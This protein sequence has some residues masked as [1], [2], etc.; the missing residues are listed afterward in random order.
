MKTTMLKKEEA[1]HDWF[2]VDAEGKGMGR[3]ATS[4][5]RRLMGKHKPVYTPHVD[6]GDFIIVINVEKVA[7]T[8]NKL[9]GKT[10][11]FYSGWPGGKYRLTL[12]ERMEKHPERVFHAAVRRMLP[13]NKLGKAML[14]KLKVY[15]GNE[16]PHAAQQ[17]KPLDL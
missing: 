3:L 6:C 9:T 5:A 14:S 1:V 15:K 13:K 12:G 17:P 7:F 10:Y 2:V 4:I 16:H 8:G 11:H